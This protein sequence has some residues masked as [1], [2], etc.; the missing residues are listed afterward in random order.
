MAL[1]QPAMKPKVLPGGSRPP[2]GVTR[3]DRESVSGSQVSRR[4]RDTF[5][6]TIGQKSPGVF[7]G[8]SCQLGGLGKDIYG[9]KHEELVH[10]M[11]K[12]HMDITLLQEVGINFTYAGING[13]WKKRLGW[14]KLVDQHHAKTICTWN[15]HHHIKTVTQFGGTAIVSLGSTTFYCIG[16]GSDPTNL[17]RWCWSRYQGSHNTHL[18]FVSFYRPNNNTNSSAQL[19]VLAQ[20]RQYFQS[21]NVDRDPYSAFL[22]DLR[23]EVLKWKHLGDSLVLCGD[24]NA[25]VLSPEIVSFFSQLGLHNLI[26]SKHNSAS[27]P[28]TMERNR[29]GIGIDGIWASPHLTLLNGGYLDIGDFPGDHRPIWFE[30]SLNDAFGRD[31]PNIWKPQAR[32]LQLRDPQCV[33]RYRKLYR[34][35]LLQHNLPSALAILEQSL[36][37]GFITHAQAIEANRIDRLTTQGQR[38]AESKCR[39]LRMGGVQ[40]SVETFLPRKQ[41]L[42][43]KLALARCEGL[44]V[45]SRR[46]ARAKAAAKITENTS[47]LSPDDI[48]ERFRLAMK[49][50]RTLR[51]EHENSR[52]QFI[53]SFDPKV[54]DRILRVEEQRRLGRISRHIN[55]KLRGG[56]VTTVLR[57]VLHNGDTTFVECS[58]PIEIAEA[59][60]IANESKYRQCDHSPFLQAPLLSAFGYIGDQ[61]ATDQV[62][63]GAYIPPPGTDPFTC[64]LLQC[65]AIPP[66]LR[67][68]E[69]P[70]S[71]ITSADH[72]SGWSR[73]KEYTSAGISGL[74][75]GMYKAQAVNTDLANYDAALRNVAYYTGFVYDR[76]KKGV[77]VML[78]KASGD[79]RVHKLRTILLMEADFNMNNKKL[80]RDG[81]RYA[82]SQSTLAPEQAGGRR[83]HRANETSL[84]SRLTCDDSRFKRKAMAICS[85]DAKGCYDR[86]IHSIAYICLRRLGIPRT[87]LLSMFRTIQS[88]SHHVRTAYGD[89]KSTYGPSLP[90]TTPLMGLLQGNGAAGTG[91]TAVSSVIVE[92]MRRQRFGYSTQGPI[93]KEPLEF[94]C[95]Q[96]VDDTDL[97]H[98]GAVNT[99]TGS[100]VVTEMQRVL[101]HWDMYLRITGGALEKAKSYWYLLDYIRRNGRWGFKSINAVPGTLELYNDETGVREPIERL[102]VN[103]ARKALG[104]FTRPDGNMAD[105]KNYLRKMAVKWAS[106]VAS[107]HIRRD[108]AWYCMT[109]TVMKS[110]EYP[111][112]TTTFSPEDCAH[113]M[114]PILSVGLRRLGIQRHFPRVLAYAPLKYQGLGIRDPWATQLIEHIHVIQR[115]CTRP[116]ITGKLLR[117]NMENLVLELGSATSFWQLDYDTWHHI[118]TPS[119]IKFTWQAAHSVNFTL[120]GPLPLPKPQRLHDVCLM[121]TFVAHGYDPPQLQ[122][123]NDVRMY[124]Q[125]THLSDITLA[126]G[127]EID[128]AFYETRSP[129]TYSPYT[130]P[131]SSR[132]RA[133]DMVL[134]K[135]ALRD[136]FLLAH[137]H[138]RRLSTPLGP[139]L[140]D[141]LPHWPWWHSHCDSSTYQ[142]V[143]DGW[144]VWLHQPTPRQ[145]HRYGSS[146]LI[147]PTLPPPATRVSVHHRP[148]ATYLTIVCHGPQLTLA[149]LP[150][151]ISLHDLIAR[152]PAEERWALDHLDAIADLRPLAQSITAKACLAVSDGSLKDGIGT[153]AFIIEGY[154]TSVK[155]MNIVPGP[156]SAG[157]SY[158]CELAGLYGILLLSRL[159]CQLFDIRSGSIHIRCDNSSALRVLD[160][161]YIPDPA[162]PSFDLVS[163]LRQLLQH[164]PI[165]FTTEHV[166]GHQDRHYAP[167]DRAATLNIEM[168]SLANTYRSH[169]AATNA[170][171][172]APIIPIA[173]EGWSVW[174]NQ[175]RLSPSYD[176]LYEHIYLPLIRQYW[177][178]H[179]QVQPTPR[180]TEDSWSAIDWTIT[181][182]FMQG[183]P[184]GQRRWITKHASENCGVGVT[185]M[186]WKLQTDD[187]CPRCQQTENTDHVLHCTARGSTD[188]WMTYVHALDTVLAGSATPD[189]LRIAL[190]SR[191]SLWHSH[192]AFPVDPSW[193]TPLRDLLLSQDSIGWRPFL[194]GLVS[195]H[196][197]PYITTHFRSIR[198]KKCPKRWLTKVLRSAHS[199]AWHLWQH[200]NNILHRIDQPREVA[201]TELLQDNIMIEYTRGP[202][203]LPIADHHHF[204]RPLLS[205]LSSS[206][207]YQQAWYLNV[208]TA[209]QRHDRRVTHHP[210]RRR[211][212]PD[213]RLI[214]WIRTG[215]WQ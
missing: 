187:L 106:S 48:K 45:S 63:A 18:R 6:D 153:S 78:L 118:A 22:E 130:W 207:T 91:W 132:P 179:H 44:P 147:L 112:V 122:V 144:R 60:T 124:L 3:N 84:N 141:A 204:R 71:F 69:V 47:L 190:L 131:R 64:Q 145:P 117:S 50:Y 203:D 186:K 189:A 177:T 161:W 72:A 101:D 105:E 150:P 29:S 163:A 212:T 139:W 35:F 148:N 58:H 205:I 98:S 143:L 200:R 27:A 14:N 173:F 57:P 136:C 211:T 151:A 10:A 195:T 7:R 46:W 36:Q 138:H 68:P 184:Q 114:A 111:L 53:E 182:A 209:R 4:K 75:F 49:R 93:S 85:N 100:D 157:D 119:W 162:A 32:R 154:S 97:V 41:A 87:P 1:A 5:G 196:W 206:K 166:Y 66:Q 171:A 21:K 42:F 90:G 193:P 88:M 59:L 65:M 115:H 99:T 109:S 43:W 15:K 169:I 76:W 62:L 167:L 156:L 55:N 192:L 120:R 28:S 213:T 94:V 170:Q 61:P 26:F 123:L 178:T 116:T 149:P 81:M 70:A 165:D 174:L 168:D 96:F 79:L 13:Q 19:S 135:Q 9:P 25:D 126:D 201:A 158:R 188:I 38:Y 31:R 134:W 82:E 107:N 103:R 54:R 34:E 160:P 172:S 194:E 191:L 83:R 140:P 12:Y 121:D 56:S 215:R 39:K 202:Q 33:R 16:S 133:N 67:A 52:L 185:L 86:I 125:V 102:H 155:A 164:S 37:P 92:A 152:L 40:F 104:I 80:S 11:T 128:I 113:I 199:I 210:N 197:I 110:I 159:L 51:K 137:A 146:E 17:G 20:H 108:D 214:T 176:T 73:M 23:D 198:S 89:S 77:D 24:I 129:V 2:L 74:H 180:L 183:L 8:V 127:T 175:H 181:H 30:L 142:R 208:T 95:F